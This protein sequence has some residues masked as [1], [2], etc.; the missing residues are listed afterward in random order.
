MMCTHK[1]AIKSDYIGYFIR[2][3]YCASIPHFVP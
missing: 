2:G 1:K 3:S